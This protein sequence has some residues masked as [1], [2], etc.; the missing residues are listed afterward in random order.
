MKYIPVIRK[1]LRELSRYPI[2]LYASNASFYI[3]LSVF[4]TV[5]LVAALLPTFGIGSEELLKVMEGI[6]PELLY[7]LFRKV[8]QDME[9]TT[10]G[11]LLSTTAI[12]AI[13]SASKGVYCIRQGGIF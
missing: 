2:S 3:F 13:W 12:V 7:P 11:V 1:H 8:L 9:G 5:M 6:I 4:P 10:T